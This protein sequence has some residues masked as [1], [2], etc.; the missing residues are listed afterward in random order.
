M[1]PMHSPREASHYLVNGLICSLFPL[2]YLS[3]TKGPLLPCSVM[4]SCLGRKLPTF[5]SLAHNI[6]HP[7]SSCYLRLF[8]EGFHHLKFPGEKQALYIQVSLSTSQD[9]CQCLSG[10]PKKKRHPILSFQLPESHIPALIQNN[11]LFMSLLVKAFRSVQHL[12]HRK[13]V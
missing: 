11:L 7:F 6:L 12:W 2:H 4:A 9:K 8:P 13:K 1:P 3:Y 5:S 10:L